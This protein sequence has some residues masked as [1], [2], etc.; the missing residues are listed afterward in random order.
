MINISIPKGKVG[1]RSTLPV[2]STGTQSIAEN[3]SRAF[4]LAY[5][6]GPNTMTFA[7]GEDADA[8]HYPLLAGEYLHDKIGA[9]VPTDEIRWY[10]S[11]AQ[12][13]YYSEA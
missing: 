10:C 13:L 1:P 9:M 7:F 4:L 2:D 6:P 5:N 11:A 3:T 12:T 8:T